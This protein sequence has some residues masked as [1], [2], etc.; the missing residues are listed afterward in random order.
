[1]DSLDWEGRLASV[2]PL[3]VDYYTWASVSS[4]IRELRPKE[5]FDD[6]ALLHAYGEVLI[7]TKA[8]GYRKIKRYTHETLGFGTIDLPEMTLD[9]EGYWLVFGEA[10]TDKLVEA[11]ILVR[12]NDYGPN[13][14]A[15]RQAALERDG[16]RCRTCGAKARPGQGLHI[17]HIRPFR[18]Y[19]YI[20]GENEAFLQANALENLVTLCPSCHRRAEVG[21]QTRSAL[22]GLAYVLGNLAP[23]FLMCDPADI[24]VS[25]ENRNPITQSPTVVVYERI[26]AGV[27]FSQR[28]FELRE[29]L[30][31]SALELVSDCRCRSGCPACVG[32][33]GEIGPDTKGVTKALLSILTNP[34]KK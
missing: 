11:G 26:A 6:S 8:T 18:E 32:P 4:T 12:P 24:Q 15:Q 30:L 20:S 29:T 31:H 13:W 2:R 34:V 21:Q 22:G 28:L 27:G 14:Q 3:E 7:V 1:V 16:H 33:P 25:A 17:H 19:G 9:T 5:E 10:L 23:L